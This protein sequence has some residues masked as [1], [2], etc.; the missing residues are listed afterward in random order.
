MMT[1]WPAFRDA[2]QAGIGRLEP[3]FAAICGTGGRLQ[4][5]ASADAAFDLVR[6]SLG[7]IGT[8]TLT[9]PTTPYHGW[10]LS[11]V[12]IT[13]PGHADAIPFAS[14]AGS[15]PTPDKGVALELFDLGRVRPP[16]SPQPV[17]GSAG[18]QCSSATSTRSLR[19]P[20][21]GAPSSRR[22]LKLGQLRPPW[23]RRFPASDR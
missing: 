1:G 4:R 16:T 12:S 20:S 13:V 9:A 5:I 22:R 21:I 10:M 15:V 6:D 19:M 18:V 17:A 2:L 23:S 3:D 8:G 7:A 14:L 11:E